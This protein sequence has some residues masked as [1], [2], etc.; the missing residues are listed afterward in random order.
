MGFWK[1]G[2]EKLIKAVKQG[3]D[4][5]EQ[6]IDDIGDSFKAVG[7]GVKATINCVTLLDGGVEN[8]LKLKHICQPIFEWV[9]T[10]KRYLES[11]NIFESTT[12]LGVWVIVCYYFQM[13][14]IPAIIIIIDAKKLFC[15]YVYGAPVE[16][17]STSNKSTKNKMDAIVETINLVR[18][19]LCNLEWILQYIFLPEMMTKAKNFMM[20]VDEDIT[21]FSTDFIQAGGDTS[22]FHQY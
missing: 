7:D 21:G 18:D 8:I 10:F 2:F 11:D 19:T 16:E 6:E 4:R 14:M 22:I 20:F 5:V 3:V 17:D 9:T 15:L 12:A 1:D 13:W